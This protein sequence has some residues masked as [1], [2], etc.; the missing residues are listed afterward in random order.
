MLTSA[1]LPHSTVSKPGRLPMRIDNT[2]RPAPAS[3]V[4]SYQKASETAGN[5]APARAT[6]TASVLGIPA[7]EL[8]P[9][10]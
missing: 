5:S 2:R 6:D 3:G 10:V 1:V 9:K 8:T 7:G 4:G